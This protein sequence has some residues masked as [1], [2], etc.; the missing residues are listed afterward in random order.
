MIEGEFDRSGRPQ[1]ITVY[2][3]DSKAE[4]Q[5]AKADRTGKT[6]ERNLMGWSLWTNKEDMGSEI[7]VVKLRNGRDTRGMKT[8]GHELAHCIYGAF[9]KEE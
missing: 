9:H 4:M 5:R 3:Y 8:W 2:V 7:H 6:R 1:R